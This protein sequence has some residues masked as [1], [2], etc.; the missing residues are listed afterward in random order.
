MVVTGTH[1][2]CLRGR[3]RAGCWI[4][5][6]PDSETEIKEDMNDNAGTWVSF[7]SDFRF[8]AEIF[9]GKIIC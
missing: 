2:C 5:F 3:A 4:R 6:K 9:A 1:L 8:K 7:N